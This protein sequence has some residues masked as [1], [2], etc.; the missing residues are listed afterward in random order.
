MSYLPSAR[1]CSMPRSF[2]RITFWSLFIG[3]VLFVRSPRVF[4]QPDTTATP[5]PLGRLVD[6]GGRRLH[7]RA[8]GI[9]TPTVIVENGS[10]SFSIDW[11]LV[12]SKVSLFTQIC[13]YDRAGF[14]WSDRGPEGNTVEEVVD[15]LHL[16]LRTAGVPPPYVLVGH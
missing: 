7:L 16:L 3:L 2:E 9:G 5:T 14:A 8:T 11:A 1:G 10:S 13:T 4:G 15:D 6:I 12:Q